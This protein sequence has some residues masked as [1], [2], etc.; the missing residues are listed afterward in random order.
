LAQRLFH[1]DLTSSAPTLEMVTRLLASRLRS[2]DLGLI[3]DYHILL[4]CTHHARSFS[5]PLPLLLNE[6]K[7]ILTSLFTDDNVPLTFIPSE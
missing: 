1:L 5:S 6:V 7:R 4:A 2:E 3:Q